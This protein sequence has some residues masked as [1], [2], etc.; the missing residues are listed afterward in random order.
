MVPMGQ[1]LEFWRLQRV[2]EVTGLSKSEIYRRVDEQ[3]FPAPRKYPGSSMNFW[4][5]NVVQ[6]WQMSVLGDGFEELLG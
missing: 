1:Q 6:N 2:C 5:S 3:R 4:P